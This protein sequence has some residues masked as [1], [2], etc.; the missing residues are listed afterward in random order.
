MARS[1][2]EQQRRGF[3]WQEKWKLG[4]EAALRLLRCRRY[5]KPN[6]H[7]TFSHMLQNQRKEKEKEAFKNLQLRKPAK[8]NPLRR[9]ST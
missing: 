4:D 3:A 5:L 6:V 8:R 2:K 7:V 1:E 9:P